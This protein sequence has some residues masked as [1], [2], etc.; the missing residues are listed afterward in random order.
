MLSE[1]PRKSLP[2]ISKLVGLKDGQTL[3][4]FWQ[5]G[6]WNLKQVRATRLR[7]IQ[8]TIGERKIALCIDERDVKKGRPL[9]GV[10]PTRLPS[11]TLATW[12]RQRI[13]LSLSMPMQ[14]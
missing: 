10:L 14:L 11:N 9:K 4:H 8:Q 2:A 12:G 1:I 7:M 6:V 3:P 13:E 5:D